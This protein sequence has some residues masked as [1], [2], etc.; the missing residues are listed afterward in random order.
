MLL[1]LLPLL[2]L[3]EVGLQ[4]QR[5]TRESRQSNSALNE[6]VQGEKRQTGCC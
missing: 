6:T 1:W 3:T 5:Q 4:R 2:A